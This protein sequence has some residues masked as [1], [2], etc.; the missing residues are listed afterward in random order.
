[1]HLTSNLR[2]VVKHNMYRNMQL[3]YTYIRICK[4]KRVFVYKSP[5]TLPKL[6]LWI[7]TPT[8]KPSRRKPICRLNPSFPGTT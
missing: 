8:L 2:T 3:I 4:D 6:S 1:M 7:S 5:R